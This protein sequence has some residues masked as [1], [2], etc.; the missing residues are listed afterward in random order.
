M[1]LLLRV[2]VSTEKSVEKQL[3]LLSA[4]YSRWWIL[5][6][7]L[8]TF[9]WNRLPKYF[10]IALKESRYARGL[11]YFNDDARSLSRVIRISVSRVSFLPLVRKPREGAGVIE[12][13]R[14]DH[15]GPLEILIL[16][17]KLTQV[18]FT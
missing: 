8:L 6:F 7:I 17:T 13:L 14:K 12:F 2:R 5:I 16:F 1:C 11:F 3:L 18:H 9:S 15:I 4:E 10:D